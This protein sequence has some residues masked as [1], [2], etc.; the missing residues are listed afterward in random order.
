M[1]SLL[2]QYYWMRDNWMDLIVAMSLL[3]MAAQAIVKLTPTKKDDS[4]LERLNG[5]FEKFLTFVPN[6]KR[7]EGKIISGTHEPRKDE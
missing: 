6:V 5:L 1:D 2:N 7:V 4:F 3:L